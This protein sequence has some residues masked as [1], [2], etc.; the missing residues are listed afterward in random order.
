MKTLFVAALTAFAATAAPAVADA[1]AASGAEIRAAIAG[2][3]VQGSMVDA[4]DYTEFYAA[5]G[6]IRG[7]GYTGSWH[8]EDNRMCFRYGN[9]AADCYGVRLDGN[10]VIWLKNGQTDGTG[11]IVTGNPSDF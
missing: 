9:G 8:I 7:D 11:T 1:R 6:T 10:R 3:T 4:S 2:N 5:N